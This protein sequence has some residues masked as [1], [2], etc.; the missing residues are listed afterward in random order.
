[1]TSEEDN[2][3][4][5]QRDSP[6]AE[7]SDSSS[8][9]TSPSPRLP[10]VP[11]PALAV[12][13]LYMFVLAG[14]VIVGVVHGYVRP[15]YLTFA[16]AFIT[17]ALGLVMLFRWAWN[18]TLAAVVLLIGLFFWRFTSQHDTPSIVQGLLNLVIF[19]YLVRPEVRSHLH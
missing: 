4:G 17:A 15:V 16:A 18:L 5:R 6:L 19:L 10:R 7:P 11:L 12:I 8:A 14:F 1:M 2:Q 9:P 13:A 3:A